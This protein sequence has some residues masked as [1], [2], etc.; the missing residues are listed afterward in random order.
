MD[1]IKKLLSDLKNYWKVP[2]KGRYMSFKEIMSLSVGG[3]GQK[4]IVYC[5]NQ[6]IISIGNVLI[7][8]TI[9]IDPKA[10]Y[11]IYIISVLS[12]FPLTA[13]RAK[14]IDNT[15]SMKGKY[16]P[17]IISMGIPTAV[18]GVLFILTPYERMNLL[19]KCILVLAYNIG[20]QFFS[21]FYNDAY[22]SLINVLSPNSIERSDVLSIKSI[23][24]NFSPSL[25]NI[26]LPIIAKLITGENT[27][28]DL[29]VYRVL[30][31]PMIIVGFFI[32]MLA[33]VNTTEKIVQAKTHVI[34]MKFSDAFRAIAKNKYFWIISLAGWLG[35]LESSFNNIIGWMYNYQHACSPAQY[36]IVTAIAGNAA[37]WP[38]VVAPFFIRK[39]GKKK[40]LVFTNVLNIF[41]IMFMLPVVRMTG[42]PGIIWFFLVCIFVNTF[43]TSLGHLLNPSIQAD[44]RD[45]QQYVTG[46]RIDGMFAAVGLI[47][48]VITLATSSVLPAIYERAGLN[49][50]VAISLGYDGSN[51]YD[52]L[53]NTDY[54][55]QISSVLI[56]ASV[57]GAI[58][59]VIPFFFY[60]LTETDQK[61]MVSVLKIRALFEDWGNGVLED[62]ALI[63]T[64]ELIKEAKEYGEKDLVATEKGSSKAEKKKI[65]EENEKIQIAHRI[66]DELTKYETEQG[67]ADVEFAV[68]IVAAGLNGF[69]SLEVPDKKTAKVMPKNTEREKEIRRNTL[70]QIENFKTS[71]K[72]VKKYFPDGIKEFDSKIFDELFKAE[73]E[74]DV[75]VNEALKALKAAK[76]AKLKNEIPELK[77]AV[78]AYQNER[79]R[80]ADEIKKATDENSIFYR[81]AKPYLDAKKL[82]NQAE[83]YTH[84]GEVEKLYYS[85]VEK[86]ENVQC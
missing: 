9:G 72:A 79:K 18:I 65:R 86:A 82:L 52:V 74:N 1:K 70:M 22:D 30:F 85:A 84:L 29:K 10:M 78:K 26:F 23:V 6:M 39:F 63:E 35:F 2:P 73:Y 60:D 32:S 62:G 16:R 31:P 61:G 66:M 28:Y 19:W 77:Q 83:N 20:F 7:G 34:Q 50:T 36:S 41:F 54:F 57:A 12:G 43:I 47:G 69:S 45:Y 58:M 17:Y 40:I 75:A 5:V 25:A 24:E 59:N 44:I 48:N 64:Y 4:F 8:N 68:K 27:L 13:L 51:V 38:N 37:F 15:R 71:K 53:Y 49:K 33:Y 80:I 56:F 21:N 67:K 55:V 42:H 3:I 14:M 76:D 46:E 81:A 11:V